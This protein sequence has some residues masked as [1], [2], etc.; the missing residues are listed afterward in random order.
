MILKYRL[1]TKQKAP[2]TGATSDFILVLPTPPQGGSGPNTL[3]V[4]RDRGGSVHGK[5][6]WGGVGGNRTLPVPLA[7]FRLETNPPGPPCQGGKGHKGH[8][9]D[10]GVEKSPP[11]Q[12]GKGHAPDEG[13]LKKPP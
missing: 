11:C 3:G 9:P 12:G 13:V 7:L 4:E 5:E 6:G 2:P 10:E 1:H 8:A